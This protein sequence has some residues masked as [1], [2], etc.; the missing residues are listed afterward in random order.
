MGTDRVGVAPLD[1]VVL[2]L[3]F[4]LVRLWVWVVLEPVFIMVLRTG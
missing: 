3:L 2:I 4:G 1:L